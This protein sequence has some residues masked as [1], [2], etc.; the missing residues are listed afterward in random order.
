VVEDREPDNAYFVYVLDAKLRRR[1]PGA[2]RD[3]P[4][5]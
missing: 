5:D 2:F 3:A 4:G 1:M